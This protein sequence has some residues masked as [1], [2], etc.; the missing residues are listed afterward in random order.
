MSIVVR[1]TP[2][3]LTTEMYDE[4]VRLLGERG[5]L[6]ADGQLLHICFGTSPN[7]VVSEVWESREQWRAFLEQLIPVLSTV[8]IDPGD[9]E[10]FEVHNMLSASVPAR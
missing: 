5:N 3:T 1:F 2:D 9:P 8:G 7:L 6:P 10:V 4:S